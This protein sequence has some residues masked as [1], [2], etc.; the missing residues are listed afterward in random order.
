MSNPDK[1]KHRPGGEMF[2][3]PQ[4]PLQRQYEALRAYLVEGVPAAEAAARFG[5]S[6]AT[7]YSLC[8]DLRAG[9]LRFFRATRPGPKRALMRDSV[10]E[11]AIALRKR[12]YSVYDIQ[13]QLRAQGITVSH[14]LVS[15]ILRK[16]GFAKLPR[17]AGVE[18]TEAAQA[19]V[20]EVAD[21]RTLDW[22]RFRQFETQAGGLFLLVPALVGWSL[23]R[24][25]KRAR[26]PG[27]QM[28][29]PLQFVL[30]LLALKLVGADRLGH[31]ADVRSDRGFALFAGL[32][33]MP[34]ATAIPTHSHRVTREMTLSLLES[35]AQAMRRAGLV[36]GQ[37]FNLGVRRLPHRG[38]DA[39][40]VLHHARARSR[41]GRSELVF[42]CQDNDSRVLCFASALRPPVDKRR[43]AEGI[44]DF[45]EFWRRIRGIPPPHLVFDPRLTTYVILDRLDREGVL[46]VTLRRRGAVLMRQLEALPPEAWTRITLSD[47][48]RRYRTAR[49]AESRV[50]VRHLRRP[51]RQ[52]AVRGLGHERPV[53]FL[54]NDSEPTAAELIARHARRMLIEDG[55]SES[56]DFFHHDALSLAVAIQPDLDAVL[57]AVATALYRVVAR[58][59]G[60]LETAEPRVVFRRL[61][62]TPARVSVTPE[63][64]VVRMPRSGRPLMR[65]VDAHTPAPPVPWWGGRTL[66]LETT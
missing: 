20:A 55:I 39:G 60:G 6:T 5:Y 24:W 12:N 28:I 65:L 47:V 42:L 61:L 57:T 27:S 50:S 14:V 46:F 7:L 10:R 2:L 29:P 56:V 32:N 21:V 41:R 43:A 51:L 15:A 37:S 34:K 1:P 45:V 18:R 66:R 33:I 62:D 11:R 63:D 35:Y 13:A 58:H 52:I 19:V 4:C 17:R 54:T 26:L 53:L 40:L 22:D 48:S 3:S 16:E 30:S 25:V 44:L 31:V 36:P 23:D 38:H 9:R 49:Y 8:R 64:V 59:V